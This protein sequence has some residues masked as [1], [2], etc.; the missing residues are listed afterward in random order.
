MSNNK[1]TFNNKESSLNINSEYVLNALEINEIKEVINNI[2]KKIDSQVK[3]SRFFKYMFIYVPE[4]IKKNSDLTIIFGDDE[5]FTNQL[6]IKLSTHLI[7]FFYF[8]NINGNYEIFNKSLL[9]QSDAKKLLLFKLNELDNIIPQ[10]YNYVKYFFDDTKILSYYN[11]DKNNQ[12]IEKNGNNFFPAKFEPM[13]FKVCINGT[14]L[15]EG[16]TTT[17][18]ATLN[19]IELNSYQNISAIYNQ[20]VISIEENIITA[21]TIIHDETIN[22]VFSYKDENGIIYKDKGLINLKKI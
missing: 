21:K 10:N 18:T 2:S 11:I 8:N 4:N 7:H 20:S 6:E 15:H 13:F 14:N 3:F 1:I 12:K 17:F 9:D 19:G 5:N 16:E 22:I